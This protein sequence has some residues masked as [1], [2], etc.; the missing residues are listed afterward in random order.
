ML[1]NYCLVVKM[2]ESVSAEDVESSGTKQRQVSPISI[3][4]IV[5]DSD[6]QTAYLRAT[7]ARE[8]NG[9][10]ITATEEL[11]IKDGRIARMKRSC[12]SEN[13]EEISQVENIGEAA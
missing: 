5:V 4:M 12:H 7:M 2:R 3:D 11:L 1:I 8:R 9:N 13:G 10:R 6:S